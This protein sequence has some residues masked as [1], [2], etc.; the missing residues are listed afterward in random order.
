MLSPEGRCKAFDELLERIG[1][2]VEHEVVR[3]APVV[4]VDLGAAEKPIV[5]SVPTAPAAWSPEKW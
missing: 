2:L 1:A 4:G 3:Q 5:E